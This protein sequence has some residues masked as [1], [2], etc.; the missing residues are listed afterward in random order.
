MKFGIDKEGRKVHYKNALQWKQYFCPYCTE[1]LVLRNGKK[2]CFAHNVIK[3][4]TPLQRTCPEYH[5][6]TVYGKID[7]AADVV[8]INNGGIPLYLCNDGNKFELRA[9]FP[10]ISENCRN[11]LIENRIEVFINKKRWCCVENL[12]YYPVYYITK[13]I[14]V[15]IKPDKEFEEVRRKWLYGI[16]GIDIENDIYHANNEGGYRVTIKANIYIGKKYRMMFSEK[17]P[18]VNG[19]V[20]KN[21]GQIKLK[22]TWKRKLFNIYEMEI[23]KFTE[24][25]RQFIEG[26]GYHLTEKINEIIPLWPPAVCN[27]KELTFDG[28]AAWFYHSP[29]SSGEYLY[30][31]QDGKMYFLSGNRAFKISDI[32][33][34]SEKAVVITNKVIKN[35]K[36]LDNADDTYVSA[37]IKYILN[38]K[39]RLNDKNLLEPKIIIKDIE[40]KIIDYSQSNDSVPE[41][42]ILSVDANVPVIARVIKDNYCVYSGRYGLEGIAY[43]S[44]VNIDCR[45]FGNIYYR[46]NKI[47]KYSKIDWKGI[48]EKFYKYKGAVTGP[49]TYENKILLYKLK[50]NLTK[51]NR[52]IYK[53]LYKWIWTEK[54]P[55]NLQG[56]LHEME[57]NMYY[58]ST[59]KIG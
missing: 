9:Y 32:S 43:G 37:E 1:K 45:G 21:I 15:S 14:D 31:I 24:E 50:R 8:Y 23:T 42:G 49:S 20:F 56:L 58:D 28:D 44:T 36:M 40:G 38:Y 11:K 13:W 33:V 48:C 27:G 22:E 10:S 59:G 53:I 39:K 34:C 2:P 29:N 17:A 52:E 16:R 54:V 30:E 6:N 7:N 19:I 12:G 41:K 26:K 51:E 47:C 4:R 3:E 18:W 46:Y 57:E 35:Q 25:A 5:E 55:V